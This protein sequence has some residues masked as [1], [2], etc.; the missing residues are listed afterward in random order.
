MKSLAYFPETDTLHITLSSAPASGGAENAGADGEHQ[1]VI[2]SYNERDKL[3]SI[4]I[5]NASTGVDL[6][7]ILSGRGKI[8]PGETEVIYSVSELA[9]KLDIVP[10]ALREIIHSM[11]DSGIQVGKRRGPT[12]PMILSER[13]AQ[14]IV[15]WRDEHPKGGQKSA[16]NASKK[17][18]KNS[19]RH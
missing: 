15:Q 3:V 4:T 10:G 19:D 16:R 12:Y 11:R 8:V 14:K 17:P 5:E 2:L 6:K 7:D 1:D 9:G 18:S 13:D